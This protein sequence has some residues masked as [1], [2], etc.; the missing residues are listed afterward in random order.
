MI[1][2]RS[3]FKLLDRGFKDTILLIPGW[4]ADHRIFDTLELDF[5][6]LIPDPVSLYDF[7]DSL[8]ASLKKDALRKI[9]ILGWSLGGYLAA[10]FA[11]NH[12]EYV[13]DIT[14]I[15]MR[16]KYDA[17]GL[18]KIKSYIKNN[19]KAYL[20]KFYN[21]CFSAETEEN[22]YLSLFKRGLM[23]DYLEKANVDELL[24]GLDYL[25]RAKLDPAGLENAKIKF[26][27]GEHD[28]IAPVRGIDG[29]KKVFQS[30]EF[31][32]MKGAGHMPFL[33]SDFKDIFYGKYDR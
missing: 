3:K 13:N 14:L 12:P 21:E 17:N 27:H 16:E 9:S 29:L 25:G 1:S 11:L 20:Y 30:A 28:K 18:E 32:I 4:A 7:E 8:T 5:N 33:R 24:E 26:I 22:R 23:R 10:G 15:G 19:K 2:R 6:Y 31:I